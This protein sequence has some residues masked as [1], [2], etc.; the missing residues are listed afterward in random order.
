MGQRNRKQIIQNK[1]KLKPRA[2][3]PLTRRESVTFSRL[4]IGHTKLTHQHLLLGEEAPFCVGCNSPLT[5]EH[6]LLD[7]TDFTDSRSKYYKSENLKALFD[8]IEPKKIINF[9]F[10]IGLSKRI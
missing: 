4:K 7:C 10:E 6:I 5:V 8:T 2:P 9:I 3:P 1:P